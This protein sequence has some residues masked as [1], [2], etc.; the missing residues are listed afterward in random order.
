MTDLSEVLGLLDLEELEPDTF[1]GGQPSARVPRVYGGQVLAQALKA[2]HLTVPPGRLPHSLHAYFIRP[3][4]SSIPMVFKVAVL[5]DGGSISS[6]RVS[7]VQR[8]DVI[9]EM[10]T[11]FC[12]GSDELSFQREMP[13]VPSAESLVPIQDQLAS[14]AQELDGWWVRPRPFDMRYVGVP[15]RMALDEPGEHVPASQLW[16]RPLG[17]APED[18]IDSYCLLAYVSDTTL[19]DSVMIMQRRTTL[20]PGSVASLDHSMW[21]HGPPDLGG[22]LLYDQHSPV[23]A[24]RRGLASGHVYQSDG[25]LVCSV[26]QEAW[27][28][29]SAPRNW[30]GPR[31]GEVTPR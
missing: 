20:G 28:S 5:R 2:A 24:A 10:S 16:V 7:A 12:Q 15:P 21:F 17:P 29:P 27:M 30:A 4:D 8:G 3:G 26:T 6:R 1:R 13:V 9:L 22:W 11:S 25:R 14:Y 23:S 31:L 19:L 18:P